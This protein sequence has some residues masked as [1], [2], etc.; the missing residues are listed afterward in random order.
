[1]PKQIITFGEI[2]LRISPADKGDRTS[3]ALHYRIEP[4][5]SEANV[6]IAL[7]HLGD[8][9]AFFT[10]LPDS[11]PLSEKVMAYMRSHGV[12]TDLIQQ[13]MGRLGLYWTENGVG[14]RNSNVLYDRHDS[15]ISHVTPDDMPVNKLS[16]NAEWFHVSGITPAISKKAFLTTKSFLAFPGTATKSIDLNYRAKLWEWLSPKDNNQTVAS[17]MRDLCQH[18][19]VIMANETDLADAL[20]YPQAKSASERH[21]VAEKVFQDFPKLKYL[22]ISLRKSESASVNDWTG[23]LYMRTKKVIKQSVGVSYHISPVVDRV[24][25]GDSFTAGIIHGLINNNDPQSTIDFA[26]S[27]SALKHTIRGDACNFQ[28]SD[29]VHLLKT[30]GSG[31]ITR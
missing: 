24:G 2:M 4:G 7:A 9:A 8:P 21:K 26:I 27:L 16:N 12:S 28:V 17:C 3:N 5:G 18:V 25:A 23:E 30:K 22:S 15:V 31:R 11:N 19:Q 14:P 29:V 1:M 20:E 10:L 6:A 13:R